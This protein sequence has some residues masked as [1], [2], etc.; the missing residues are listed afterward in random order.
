MSGSG[1]KETEASLSE[2]SLY[3]HVPFCAGACDYCDF[4]SI[5]VRSGDSKISAYIN[6]LLLDAALLFKTYNPVSVPT[7]YIG[8]GTPSLLGAAGMGRLLKGINAL[9]P[10]QPLEFTVEANPESA[11]RAFLETCLAGGVTRVSLGVQTFDENSRRLIHRVGDGAVLPERLALAAELFPQNFSG[12]LIAGLPGQNETALLRDLEQLA[13]AFPAHV[14]LY[15]LTVEEGTPLA[16]NKAGIVLP[17]AEEADSLWIFGRDALEKAGYHQYEVS[18]FAQRGKES[19]HNMRYW[20]MESWLALGP[21]ASSTII[22]DNFPAERWT[23]TPDVEAWLNREAA[24]QPPLIRESLDSI[25]LLKETLMMG[26]RCLCGPDPDLFKKRFGI[27][28]EAAAPRSISRWRSRGLLLQNKPALNKT[29]LLLLDR[30]LIDCF[31][32]LEE[33]APVFPALSF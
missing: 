23:V 20:R 3:I 33:S 13:A 11:D 21:A 7:V 19:R 8:G 4:Y 17:G 22:G 27:T 15:A 10:A 2:A 28:V 25:T 31:Q 24:E 5:P 26:F 14:S 30:F 6:R 18:N 32:E 1:P 9:L 12:D 29:G 16:E